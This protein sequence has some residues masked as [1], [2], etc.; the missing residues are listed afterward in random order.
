M[1]GKTAV[2]CVE[3]AGENNSWFT[4]FTLWMTVSIRNTLLWSKT[5]MGVDCT[6][7]IRQRCFC[8]TKA[9]FVVHLESLLRVFPPHLQLSQYDQGIGKTSGLEQMVIP[10]TWV[11]DKLLMPALIVAKTSGPSVTSPHFDK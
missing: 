1:H 2:G 10:A 3:N 6:Y 7:V 4:V 11:A 5:H 8:Q 9:Y